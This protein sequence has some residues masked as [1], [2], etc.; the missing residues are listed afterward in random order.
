MRTGLVF[1]SLQAANRQLAFGAA[2]MNTFVPT[3]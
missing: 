2:V 3:V 1:P